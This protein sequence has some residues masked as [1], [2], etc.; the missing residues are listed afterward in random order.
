MSVRL[1][2]IQ[3]FKPS[4][5]TPFGSESV[6]RD[7]EPSGL[8]SVALHNDTLL[9][10]RFI[11]RIRSPSKAAAL[12]FDNLLNVKLARTNGEAS[13]FPPA[14]FTLTTVTL[15]TIWCGTHM[16]VP[17]KTISPALGAT[18]TLR[19]TAPFEFSRLRVLSPRSVTQIFDPS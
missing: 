12:G 6:P 9:P 11:T 10:S 7:V 16:F 2:T 14:S 17:S 19:S 13:G 4:L 1:S 5:Q 3:K 15:L 18:G 8:R